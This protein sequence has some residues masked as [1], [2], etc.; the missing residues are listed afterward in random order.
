MSDE[1]NDL[2]EEAGPVERTEPPSRARTDLRLIGLIF[3]LPLVLMF[4]T[5]AVCIAFVIARH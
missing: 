3:L 5:S 2:A 1:T 4:V